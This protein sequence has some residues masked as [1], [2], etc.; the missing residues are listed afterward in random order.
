MEGQ[1][2]GRGNGPW[3]LHGAIGGWIADSQ[4]AMLDA[5]PCSRSSITHMA[6]RGT[7]KLAHSHRLTLPLGSKCGPLPFLVKRWCRPISVQH[8]NSVRQETG[9]RLGSRQASRRQAIRP[10]TS[11]PGQHVHSPAC[12]PCVHSPATRPPPPQA[13][14][15]R[16]ARDLGVGVGDGEACRER[17]SWS[18]VW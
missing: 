16:R 14:Q 8:S 18:S 15:L 13:P 17:S 2:R 1:R 3:T 6:R 12:G 9:V 11:A 5:R 7:C 4:R 10:R